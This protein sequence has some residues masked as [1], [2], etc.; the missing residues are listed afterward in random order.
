[1]EDMLRAHPLIS[2]AMVVGDGKPFIGVLLTL[3][4]DALK[5][6]KAEHN[7]PANRTMKEVATDATLRAEIQDAINQVNT[8]VSHAEA[9]KKFFILESDLTEED[10]E[11]TPTMKVKRYVVAQRYA[12]AIDQIYSSEK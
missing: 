4:E 6:W 8:T 10:N 2:Q 3:D 7:I 12:G 1:M 9:I 11:L 5:R